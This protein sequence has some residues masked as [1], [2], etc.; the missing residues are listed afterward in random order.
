MANKFSIKDNIQDTKTL[1]FSEIAA[2]KRGVYAG[3][4][5]LDYNEKGVHQLQ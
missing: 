5:M 4:Q 1:Y 3:V 2:L